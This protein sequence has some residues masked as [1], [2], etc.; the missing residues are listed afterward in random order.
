MDISGLL[1]KRCQFASCKR[2][3]ALSDMPCRCKM[4]FC[5]HHRLGEQHACSFDY[6]K[7]GQ[8]LLAKQLG[9][10]IIAPKIVQ[11]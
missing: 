6:K 7:I 2:K 9:P 3:L 10:P 1:P 8:E 11:N 5:Q 4:T